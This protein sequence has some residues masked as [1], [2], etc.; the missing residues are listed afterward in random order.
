M[1]RRKKKEEE[2]RKMCRV[3]SPVFL[4]PSSPH[5]PA[6]TGL[7]QITFSFCLPFPLPFF[8]LLLL[9]KVFEREHT[10]YVQYARSALI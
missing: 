10:A 5:I 4:S 7:Y 1:K 6:F 3:R 8:W 9:L 2:G